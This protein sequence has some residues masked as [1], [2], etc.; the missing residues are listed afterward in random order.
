MRQRINACGSGDVRGQA[1]HERSIERCH[2]GHE[3]RIDD[4]DFVVSLRIGDHGSNGDFRARARRGWHSINWQ[5]A[6]SAFE[7]AS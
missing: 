5:G 2:F 4:D 6:V 3:A 7:V 1:G